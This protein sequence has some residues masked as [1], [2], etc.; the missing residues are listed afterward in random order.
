MRWARFP[1]SRMP[2]SPSHPRTQMPPE[3]LEGRIAPAVF[4]LSGTALTLHGAGGADANNTALAAAGSADLAVILQSG[5]SL[6]LDANGNDIADAGETVLAKVTGGAGAFFI[7]DL[8]ANSK[9]SADELTGIATRGAFKAVITGD[10]NGDVATLLDDAGML[11]AGPLNPGTMAGLTVTGKIAGKLLAGGS[12][13]NVF[14]GG[15]TASLQ[16]SVAEIAVG[17]AADGKM[18]SFDHGGA[19]IAVSAT[20]GTTGVAG[21]SIANVVLAGGATYL[22][23][24][25]GGSNALGKAGSGGSVTKVQFL[26][27]PAGVSIEAGDGG[28]STLSVGAGGRGGSLGTIKIASAAATG[29]LLLKAGNGGAGFTGG[30]GG[31]IAASSLTL[32]ASTTGLIQV[33]AGDGGLGGAG[34]VKGAGGA[35]G[36]VSAFALSAAGDIGGISVTGGKGGNATSLALGKAGAGGGLSGL[37]IQAGNVAAG[38]DLHSGAGGNALSLGTSA[39]GGAVAKLVLTTGTVG[40]AVDILAGN[41][42]LSGTGSGGV[43]G[44]VSVAALDLGDVAGFIHVRAG[45]GGGSG[46]GKSGAGGSATGV[47]A[48]LHGYGGDGVQIGGSSGGAGGLAGGNGGSTVNTT[49]FLDGSPATAASVVGIYAGAGGDSTFGNARGGSAGAIKGTKITKEAGAAESISVTTFGGG[50]G[51]GTGAGGNGGAISGVTFKA[52]VSSAELAIGNF[53]GG[54]VATGDAAR[55]GNGGAVSKVDISAPATAAFTKGISIYGGSGG[56]ASTDTGRGGSGGSVSAVRLDAPDSL[57]QINC[58]AGLESLGGG[59]GGTGLKSAGGNGG[60][61]S[62]VTGKIGQLLVVGQRGGDADGKGGVG[63]SVSGVN[64]SE[65]TNFVQFIA[66]GTG[67]N[68]LD[69]LGTPGRGG[70]IAAVKVAGDVGNFA[71]TFNLDPAATMASGTPGMGGLVAGQAGARSGEDI[72]PRLNGSITGVSATRIA[73]ILAGNVF[74]KPF[75][76]TKPDGLTNAHAVSKLSGIA[77]T[78]IGADAVPGGGFDFTDVNALGFQLG[79]GDTAKDGLVIVLGTAKLP[80]APLKLIEV[81]I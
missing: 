13:S 77:A 30:A 66:G 45:Q 67:G 48:R 69:S 72:D 26:A 52:L 51:V 37:T 78:V 58:G 33:Q 54:G 62:G 64:L 73:A 10:V 28:A 44:V 70:N 55:G 2:T 29:N 35:G 38:I 47:T 3:L 76:G 71:A 42:G 43:G 74:G 65:V 19:Q 16:T 31:G 53:I 39:P 49:L 36:A 27:A 6:V 75:T 8:D 23:A 61:V 46:T 56:D 14:I 18:V 32:A 20:P 17:T 15:T 68:A 34:P 21:G 59:A 60:A 11:S 81:M 1:I 63:G 22:G 40:G 57:L 9:V 50:Q 80:V 79:G 41:G 24:G 7:T 5:D 25:D 12:I 4:L